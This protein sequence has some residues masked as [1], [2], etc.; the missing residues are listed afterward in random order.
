MEGKQTVR[1]VP[2]KVSF[3]MGSSNRGMAAD[4]P[5]RLQLRGGPGFCCLITDTSTGTWDWVER[6]EGRMEGREKRKHHFF[7]VE[8]H[9][10]RGGNY[11]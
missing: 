7:W 4:S 10:F 2:I 11:C 8:T 9:I 5:S 3:E 1:S 6:G